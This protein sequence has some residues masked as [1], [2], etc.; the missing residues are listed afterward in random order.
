MF[1]ASIIIATHNRASM[2]KETLE[3]MKA[4][5]RSEM[6][7][8]WIVINNNSTDDTDKV[9]EAFLDQLPLKI[10]SE[11][12]PGKNCAINLALKEVFL[13]E[14]VVFTDDDTSPGRDWLKKIRAACGRWPGHSV[15]GGRIVPRW[16]DGE[17]PVWIKDPFLLSFGFSEHDF[18]IE[19]KPY[20]AGSFPFGPNFWVRKG[21]FDGGR[22][23]PEEMG[24]MGN[25]RIMGSETS[26]LMPLATQGYEMIYCPDAMVEHRIKPRDYLSSVLFKRAYNCGRGCARLSGIY[27]TDL[28]RK[29]P[30][31]WYARECVKL[32]LA[33]IKLVVGGLETSRQRRVEKT[34]QNFIY[35][36]R[37]LETT[38]MA[39]RRKSVQS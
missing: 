33:A 21:V 17:R 28:L 6:D 10:L 9:L 13:H 26:F 39:L 22:L 19:E 30:A 4:V 20:P 25:S 36:G 27:Y 34:C 16:P 11:A 5:D 37:T 38:R 35:L 3:S 31:V 29:R 2:L 15:F 24:P 12:K 7:V 14:V 23:Y 18:G 1:S 32:F 8:Q